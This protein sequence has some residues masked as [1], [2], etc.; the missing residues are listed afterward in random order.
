MLD[1][2]SHFTKYRKNRLEINW[3]NQNPSVV[4]I[5]LRNC[6]PRWCKWAKTWSNWMERLVTTLARPH[7]TIKCART[8]KLCESFYWFFHFSLLFRS[9][10]IFNRKK[11]EV[12]IFWISRKG[13]FDID[14]TKWLIG[15]AANPD[16]SESV[17]WAVDYLL[18]KIMMQQARTVIMPEIIRKELPF[19]IS[20]EKL[21]I[22]AAKRVWQLTTPRCK[23]LMEEK[24][25][26]S[27]HFLQL[28]M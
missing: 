11:V 5:I 14:P 22:Q 23:Q 13:S 2:V 4:L 7:P 21:I 24:S 9:L 12:L 8:Q 10:M 16:S 27:T 17:V 3:K 1:S 15:W 25:K 26:V 6:L 19:W 18:R 28:T 20:L